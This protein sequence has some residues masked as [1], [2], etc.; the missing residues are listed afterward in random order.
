M[1]GDTRK[2]VN[3]CKLKLLKRLVKEQIIGTESRI[4]SFLIEDWFYRQVCERMCEDF[5]GLEPLT[6]RTLNRTKNK[7]L[8]GKSVK[9]MGPANYVWKYQPKSMSGMWVSW[10]EN[11][12]HC[13][14]VSQSG[15]SVCS[16]CY[17]RGESK[18][19]SCRKYGTC[20]V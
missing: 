15:T 19:I 13:Q 5:D 12:A 16:M 10:P 7:N 2:L 20:F 18:A 14:Q 11:T 8:R 9:G 6:R 3:Q 17:T 1:A 4:N